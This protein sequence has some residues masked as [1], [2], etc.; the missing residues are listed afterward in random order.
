MA[1]KYL[2]RIGDDDVSLEIERENGRTL[3]RR[4]SEE[5]W[6]EVQLAS[7]GHSG[8]HVLMVD[9]RP[10]E[11]HLERRRG[12]AIVTVGRHR[13]DCDV[14]PWRPLPTRAKARRTAADGTVAVTAPMTGS[15]VEVRVVVGDRVEAGQVVAVIEAMKMNN[16]LRSP[17][18]GTVEAVPLRAG[19]R[20]KPG[21]LIV[22]I[23][24]TEA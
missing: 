3:I 13:F 1:E 17:A 19:D 18:R 2:I 5:E 6:H 9:H 10:T 15:L 11:L 23:R 14:G 21:E 7:V 20:V 22:R 24:T 12:G 4:E 8:L 16:E